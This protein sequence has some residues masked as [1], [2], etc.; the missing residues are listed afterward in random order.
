MDG[1]IILP[2]RGFGPV[3]C[4]RMLCTQLQA[5][6]SDRQKAARTTGRTDGHISLTGPHWGPPD[7]NLGDTSTSTT[8][9]IH[10]CKTRSFISENLKMMVQQ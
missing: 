7:P 3:A 4:S 8:Y 10:S 6:C 9:K 1:H 2:L 5:A